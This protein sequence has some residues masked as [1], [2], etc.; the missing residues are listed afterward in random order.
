MLLLKDEFTLYQMWTLTLAV[1][2]QQELCP[3]CSIWLMSFMAT[4]EEES[5]QTPTVE[6][7]TDVS[8]SAEAVN[9]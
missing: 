1:F 9:S 2:V 3:A 6:V 5:W 7:R 4:R 8:S